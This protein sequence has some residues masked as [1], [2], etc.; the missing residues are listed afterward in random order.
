MVTRIDHIIVTPN[1]IG[2]ILKSNIIQKH[3]IHTDHNLIECIIQINGNI[4]STKY[5]QVNEKV[6]THKYRNKNL[7]KDLKTLLKNNLTKEWSL[8][9]NK[10][11]NWFCTMAQANYTLMK[12]A[13]HNVARKSL[14][15][16][17]RKEKKPKHSWQ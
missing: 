9:E 11:Q 3:Y 14:E 12:Q 6:Y 5:Q 10:I 16:I 13:I 4:V 7:T 2:K 1:L 8:I 15:I 17:E